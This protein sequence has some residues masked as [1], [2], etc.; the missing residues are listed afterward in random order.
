MTQ[1]QVEV[2]RRTS[3]QAMIQYNNSGFHRHTLI[4]IGL[5][6]AFLQ[7]GNVRVLR[8]HAPVKVVFV[9]QDNGTNST[10]LIDARVRDIKDDGAR[11]VFSNLDLP[12]HKALLKLEQRG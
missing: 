7:M 8:S 3:V 12:A 6:G 2:S 10:H 4:D 1:K 11:L 5:D 9:H